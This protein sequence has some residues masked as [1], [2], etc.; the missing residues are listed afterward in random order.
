MRGNEVFLKGD[1][2]EVAI[3]ESQIEPVMMYRPKGFEHSEDYKEGKWDG[4]VHLYRRYSHSFPRGMLTEV[5][6]LL[7]VIE[8]PY[9]VEDRSVFVCERSAIHNKT[10]MSKSLRPYQ[11]DTS[12]RALKQ[13]RGIICLPTGT[14]KTLVSADII[15]KIG[16]SA[17]I[18]VHKLDLMEQWKASLCDIYGIKPDEVGTVGNGVVDIKPLT[19]AMVQTVSKLPKE[20]FENFG[21]TV[22]DE[23]HHVAADLVYDIAMNSRSK[24]LFGLSATPYRADGHDMKIT[25][26][27]GEHIIKISLTD[28]IDQGY[29]ARPTV[30]ML[31]VPP[32]TYARKAKYADIYRDYIVD[33]EVRNKKIIDAVNIALAEKKSVYVHVK[34]LRHGELLHK[35]I[36]KSVWISGTTNLKVRTKAI[37]V[38]Q[39]EGGCLI[40]DLLGEGVDVPG[41]DVLV[42]ACGGLSEVF[43]RQLIGRVLRI[44][45]DKKAV[46]IIDFMDGAKHLMKHSGER[47]WVYKTEK[48]FTVTQTPHN[49][50]ITVVK[51]EGA[52]LSVVKAEN[53]PLVCSICGADHWEVVGVATNW[54]NLKDKSGHLKTVYG[55]LK[56]EAE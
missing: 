32:R 51:K 53:E 36:P 41:M 27:L 31:Q 34:I 6:T 2:R 49:A 50:N 1:N 47:L 45:A 8:Q 24:Y 16:T 28:M 43:V 46:E 12:T 5:L 11:K 21:C 17:V 37:S 15:R 22:I 20:L 18:F 33:N 30:R 29:L 35:S 55:A 42:M 7:E 39:S 19:V 56:E 13:E 23:C 3:V 52:K 40:S 9:K 10:G 26:A 48:A 54:V 14:G 25:G 44:S 38:F 4:F